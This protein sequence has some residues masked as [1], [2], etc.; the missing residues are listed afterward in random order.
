MTVTAS[1]A[2]S[3]LA[4]ISGV[5]HVL[6]DPA[7]V[8]P[9][10]ID[11]NVPSAA[12]LPGSRDEL[13]EIVNFCASEKLAMVPCGGRSKLSMGA[14][15][16]PYDVAVDVT[17][18]DRIVSYD[19]NDLTLSV[20]PGIPLGRLG[21]VLA[22]HRQF[23]PLAVPFQA[24]ATAG[25]AVACGVHSPL[26]QLYGTARDFLLGVEFVTGDGR[27]V[28]S[29]GLVVKNVAGYDLHKLMVGALGTLGIITKLNFRTF[30]APAPARVFAATFGSVEGAIDFRRRILGSP[31][32]PLTL[33]VLSP[34]AVE[35]LSGAVAAQFEPGTAP[36]DRLP[37][38][39][40]ALVT[41]YAGSGAV[42][43]RYER[44]LA[45]M[46]EAVG[47]ESHEVF[48]DEKTPGSFGRLREFVPIALASSP[49]TVVIRLST[50]PTK[51]R[52][53]LAAAA[54]ACHTA[55]VRWAAMIDGLGTGYIA[56]LPSTRDKNAQDAA[57]KATDRILGACAEFGGNSSIPWCPSEWKRLL[58]I[59]GP[60]RESI[61][62]MRKLKMTFD[63][64]GIF[65]PGRFA[66][67]I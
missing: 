25:G 2:A 26:R 45:E 9:Y 37:T 39:T 27:L 62:Q 43:G 20:E 1:S 54:Q 55:G 51:T 47:S 19:P 60:E 3:R 15:P 50:L 11:G 59:W 24:R 52:A 63:P 29:G 22:G 53:L 4:E 18:L 42:P 28:K 48:G 49:A 10:E 44:E 34:S 12:V 38:D 64:A 6:S 14:P 66:G 40:W 33:E 57:R 32:R 46:A 16:A 21:G 61:E 13:A 56:L 35:M 7:L 67:G 65:A 5:S 30:P 31:L 8:R 36:T 41:T 58:K 23:L 17:R